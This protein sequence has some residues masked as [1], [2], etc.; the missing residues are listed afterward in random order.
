ME[1]WQDTAN[2]T[3]SSSEDTTFIETASTEDTTN[4]KEGAT[5]SGYSQLLGFYQSQMTMLQEKLEAA[6]YRNGY[7][8][9]QLTGAETQLKLLPDFQAKASEAETL[10]QKVIELEA[11]LR[12]GW[13]SR[14]RS[15]FMT[16]R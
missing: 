7:L 16:G 4:D 6:T 8:E 1:S 12:R 11:E 15:W 5:F 2:V 14:F 9:A 13:W 3:A 10:K